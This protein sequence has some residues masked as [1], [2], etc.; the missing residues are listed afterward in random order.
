MQTP[1]SA[2][3]IIESCSRISA[4]FGVFS[5]H[6]F[7]LIVHCAAQPSHDKGREIPLLEF[8]VNALGTL[9]LFEATRRHCPEAVFIFMS[10]N[11][12][13]R[14][15]EPPVGSKPGECCYSSL[16]GA[17]LSSPKSTK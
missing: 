16:V 2:R 14:N 5:A 4:G 3:Q 7:D 13:H 11:H 8:E 10:T 12:E 9:N 17:V 6:R 1:C 15:Q